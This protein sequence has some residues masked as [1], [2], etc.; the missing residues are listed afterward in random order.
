M[1]YWSRQGPCKEIVGTWQAVADQ[2]RQKYRPSKMCP[3]AYFPVEYFIA[4]LTHPKGYYVHCGETL[5]CA[6]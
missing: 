3:L 1:L 5:Y 4:P 6:R 2:W